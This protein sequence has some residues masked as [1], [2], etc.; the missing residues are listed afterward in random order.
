M[1][2]FFLDIFELKKAVFLHFYT[3]TY[4]YKYTFKMTSKVEYICPSIYTHTTHVQYL[5]S[6]TCNTSIHSSDSIHVP[7]NGHWI[8]R[9]NAQDSLE[10][11]AIFPF[12]L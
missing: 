12:N 1:M 9:S 2:R 11:N 6:I 3:F 5:H 7:L 8:S 4:K 10:E